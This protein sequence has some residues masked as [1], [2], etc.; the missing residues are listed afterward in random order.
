[1]KAHNRVLIEDGLA[2]IVWIGGGLV[3]FALFINAI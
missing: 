1:M 3:L 2:W